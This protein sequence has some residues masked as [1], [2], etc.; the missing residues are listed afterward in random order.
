MRLDLLLKRENFAQIFELS[1]EKFLS[2]KLGIVTLIRWRNGFKSN[3]ALLVNHKLNVIYSKNIDRDK[4]RVVVSE[5]AYHPNILRHFLQK[6][7]IKLASNFYFERLFVKMRV[8]VK[9]WTSSLDDFCI[10]P[11]NHS[12]RIIDLKLSICR[13]VIK[14]GHNT[15]FI[16]NEIY[17]RENYSFLP[18]PKLLNVDS[19]GLWYEEVQI[20]ALPLN[21]IESQDIK[22]KALL[23]AQKSLLSL[24]ARTLIKVNIFS[25]LEALQRTSTDLI[26]KLPK[27]YTQKDKNKIDFILGLL[28]VDLS[29][30]DDYEIKLV[31]SHGDF[32]PANIL[33]DNTDQELYL[34]DWEYSYKRSIYYDALVYASHCRSPKG[35][36]DRLGLILNGAD[37]AYDWCVENTSNKLIKMD[38]VV[39]LIEDLIV[40]LSELQIPNMINKNEGFEVW[41]NE[42]EKWTST[43]D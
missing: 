34:I 36:S 31:L 40:R 28:M 25:Y 5:Y 3:N 7:Y 4:L 17:L 24:Y 6:C 23:R 29:K 26:I 30:L 16:N 38:L 2:D 1:L 14:D 41:L 20:S 42:V 13:V 19:L 18:I 8:E 21:R 32:Q 43:Y 33:V 11:G 39:F 37:S 27:V 10:I 12:I 22:D 35:L 15:Q 9:P